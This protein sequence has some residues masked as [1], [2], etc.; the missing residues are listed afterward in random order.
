MP[1]NGASPTHARGARLERSTHVKDQFSTHS[2]NETTDQDPDRRGLSHAANAGKH[3]LAARELDL[4][5]TPPEAVRALLGVE[6]LPHQIWEPAAGRGSIVNTLRDA[7]HAVIASDIT[8]YGLP[9][10]Y[11]RDFLRVQKMPQ[12]CE[13]IITNPPYQAAGEFVAHALTLSPHVI[14]LRLAFLESVKRTPVLEGGQ[15]AR[16]HV[17]RNRLPRMHRN[18]WRGP[19]ASSSIAF[20]WFVW[21]RKHS[22]PTTIDRISWRP[23]P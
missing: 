7:G 1:R 3:S 15:L 21:D 14:M 8:D 10:H 6:A 19:K 16:V 5:S 4:Y 20:A 17:F 23:T 2:P 12:G 11:R 9:L 22:G 13:A 18:S